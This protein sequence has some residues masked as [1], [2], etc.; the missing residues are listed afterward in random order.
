[1]IEAYFTVKFVSEII[2]L[3]L[4]GIAIL[5]VLVEALIVYLAK[6]FK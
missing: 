1:M 3:V 5:L 6:K 4:T 2:I